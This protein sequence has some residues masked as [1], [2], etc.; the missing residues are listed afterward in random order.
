MKTLHRDWGDT[1][2]DGDG[3]F[4]TGA[5]VVK[6]LG[7]GTP[8]PFDRKLSGK[9]VNP[10]AQA[11]FELAVRGRWDG[12]P[13]LRPWVHRCTSVLTCE[14]RRCYPQSS[15]GHFQAMGEHGV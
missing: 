10:S 15:A 4:E 8:Y 6:N 11:M 1:A 5:I 3:G 2:G 9:Y 14:H 13:A 7:E 12:N